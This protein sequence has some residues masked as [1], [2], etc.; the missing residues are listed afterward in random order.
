MARGRPRT[1]LMSLILR[2]KTI[3]S[4]EIRPATLIHVLNE[5][6]PNKEAAGTVILHIPV[7]VETAMKLLRLLRDKEEL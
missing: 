4:G 5:L 1:I 6:E 3:F 7:K 2:G